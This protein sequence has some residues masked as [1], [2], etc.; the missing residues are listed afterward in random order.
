MNAARRLSEVVRSVTC[1]VV[2]DGA[3]PRR[4]DGWNECEESGGEVRGRRGQSIFYWHSG[5]VLNSQ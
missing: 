2:E 4:C 1:F 5:T 3:R